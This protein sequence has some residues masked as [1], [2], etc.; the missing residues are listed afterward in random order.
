MSNKSETI[1][2]F[3]AEHESMMLELSLQG[4]E[5]RTFTDVQFYQS[6]F[7]FARETGAVVRLDGKSRRG[8]AL[9]DQYWHAACALL[10]DHIARTDLIHAL[11]LTYIVARGGDVLLTGA[12]SSRR[13]TLFNRLVS[14]A[15]L[16]SDVVN[17]LRAE[18]WFDVETVQELI[19]RGDIFGSQ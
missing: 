9:Y 14:E 16:A 6:L 12:W 10:P 8:V 5:I 4:Q 1:A 3:L 13:G 7:A 19:T 15:T 17:A 11:L 2:M 18:S